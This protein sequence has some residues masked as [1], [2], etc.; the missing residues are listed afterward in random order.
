MAKAVGDRVGF[1]T[2]QG[3]VEGTIYS[4][5]KNTVR[6]LGDDS[7][8]YKASITYAFAP[9]TSPTPRELSAK[10]DEL[11]KASSQ[12][13]SK[14]DRASIEHNGRIL[15]GT[16]SRG[17]ARPTMILDGGEQKITAPARQFRKGPPLPKDNPSRMDVW[18]V[19]KYSA[20]E[21]L[22][23]ETA[24]YTADILLNGKKV[25][26]ASNQG[27]G[28]PDIYHPVNGDYS[29]VDKFEKDARLWF[30]DHGIDYRSEAAAAWIDFYVH[31]RPYGVTTVAFMEET[32]KI[33][34]E[35]NSPAP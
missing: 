17:G 8:L 12:K 18:S 10:F 24:C 21:K 35:I 23:E 1:K 5:E 16:I 31:R 22:S 30:E 19:N 28:G 34:R 4:V 3:V 25:I 13:W 14:G 15:N 20:V 2:R 33:F 6:V 11:M 32:K 7:K 26:E 9:A 27:V 29:L